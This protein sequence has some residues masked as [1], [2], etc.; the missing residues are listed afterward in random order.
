MLNST[1]SD[2]NFM[3]TIITS[4]EFW[5]Y[6]YDLETVIFLTMKIQREHLTLPP[7]NAACHQLTLLT[8]GKQFTQAYEVSRSPHA[9]LKS[10]GF[11]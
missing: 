10:T 2:P 5:V 11:S 8:R 6:G 3:N 9:S 1:N 7:S 4:D